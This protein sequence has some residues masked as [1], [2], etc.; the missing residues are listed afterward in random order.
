MIQLT[1]SIAVCLATLAFVVTD[2]GGSSRFA[3]RPKVLLQAPLALVL[4]Q[5]SI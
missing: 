2:S 3:K 4:A 5:I 1:R